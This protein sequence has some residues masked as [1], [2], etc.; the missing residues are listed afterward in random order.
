MA[1]GKDAANSGVEKA[2]K[3]EAGP[4]AILR[5]PEVLMAISDK[6][7]GSTLAELSQRLKLPKTSLHRLLHT[8][9]HGGFLIRQAGLY[10]PGPES[11]RLAR[12]IAQA[13]PSQ[14]FPAC[15]RPVLEWLAHETGET[16]TLNALTERGTESIYI[17]VIESEA[18]LRFTVRVGNR[19]PLFSVASGKAMLAFLPADAQARYL[20]Q[21]EFL[22]FTAETTHKD[23][24]PAVLR[25]AREQAVV[26]DRNGIVDG[27]SGIASPVFGRDGALFCAIS[28]AGPT[29]RV[30]AHRP[31]L[32]RLVLDAGERISRILGFSDEYPPPAEP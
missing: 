17:D 28:V 16:V 27:A 8:L 24:M 18:P 5:V 9:E 14:D 21:T 23:A 25:A 22:E 12:L 32:E 30:E 2:E 6:R 3:E 13:A 29:D 7:G 20:E 15:A 11:F 4:R 1:P 26:F 19:R 31:R 10:T